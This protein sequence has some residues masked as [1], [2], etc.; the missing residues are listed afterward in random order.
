LIHALAESHNNVVIVL[1]NGAPVEMPWAH[2]V[3]GILE[4]YLGGQAGAGAI[5]DILFGKTNPSGKLAETFPL[6]LEDNPSYPYFPGGPSIVEYRESIFVGYRYYDTVGQRVLFPFGYGLS[7][8]TFEYS[9]IKLSQSVTN[10][11]DTLKVSLKVKNT[12]KVMGKEV[13]QLYVHDVESTV[14]RPEKELK[15]FVKI[16]LNPGE[17]KDVVI[18]LTPR[19]FAYFDT[20]INDWHVEAGTFEILL[21]ASSQDIRLKTTVTVTSTQFSS[22]FPEKCNPTVYHNLHIG[23]C[24][25]QENFEELLGRSVPPNVD[26][27][28]GPYSINT[29]IGDMTSSFIGRLL[30]R[31]MEKLLAKMVAGQ[32]ESPTALLMESMVRE[33]PLRF[34]LM[35][36]NGAITREILDSLIIMING[37]FFKGI[38]ALIKAIYSRKKD[39]I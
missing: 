14:F 39:I 11:T 36:S 23:T 35:E 30:R 10:D 21:G 12:G 19:A 15:G 16:T 4:G 2:K 27:K 3:S 22:T 34:M 29:P 8:T 13:I 31:I 38:I 20:S 37:H 1:S 5:I 18:E 28:K 6:K 17:E 32:E 33:A 26:P 7:Y 25:N 9:D 24:I